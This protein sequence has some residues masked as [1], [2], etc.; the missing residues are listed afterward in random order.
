MAEELLEKIPPERRWAITAKT[1]LGLAVLQGEKIIAPEMGKDKGII[2]PVLGAQ[3]W[4]EINVK[5]YGAEAI[6]QLMFWIKK[7]F[8]IPVEDAIGASKLYILNLTLGGGPD[9]EWE[10]IEKTP[11]R[12]VIRYPKCPYMERYR[13]FDVDPA[14][15]PC[16]VSHKRFN[17][18][19]LK[20]INPKI[21]CKLT[22]A[23]PFGDPYCEDIFELRDE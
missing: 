10:Y 3:K 6:A 21:T 12:V 14:L 4:H 23:M 2:A 19:Q 8:D 20:K 1:L 5:I 9:F 15:I 17:E 7:T 18:E 16:G 13:E 22:K 11:E